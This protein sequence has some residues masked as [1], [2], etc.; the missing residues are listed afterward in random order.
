MIE[1]DVAWRPGDDDCSP[2]L[3]A[4]AEEWAREE[5]RYREQ[6]ETALRMARRRDPDLDA[7][8]TEW[9]TASYEWAGGVYGDA[10]RALIEQRK[11][12]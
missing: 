10:A 11:T 7:R 3:R 4:E 6:R 12:A 8:L 9:E 1:R 2:P 5:R